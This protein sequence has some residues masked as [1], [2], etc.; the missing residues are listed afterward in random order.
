MLS[1]GT[2]R[3]DRNLIII[4]IN[5]LDPARFNIARHLNL[6]SEYQ[7]P[8]LHD[9]KIFFMKFDGTSHG[10]WKISPILDF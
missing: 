6:W 4:I 2:K 5:I 10:F 1:Q 7:P 3:R 9:G 8:N